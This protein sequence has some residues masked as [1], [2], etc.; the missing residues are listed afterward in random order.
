MEILECMDK[1]APVIV[2]GDDILLWNAR[3]S[4]RP[5]LSFGQS[6]P[7]A[8]IQAINV[9]NNPGCLSFDVE[10]MDKKFHVTMPVEGEHYVS[11]A[12]AAISVGL[13]MGVE[14]EK[15]QASGRR[16]LRY[17]KIHRFT[18]SSA[19]GSPLRS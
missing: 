9:E 13:H 6:N 12:L 8:D 16:D 18:S 17:C 2:N 1:K 5:F 19:S 11:D 4:G 7:E 15:I 14:V 10:G 3:H